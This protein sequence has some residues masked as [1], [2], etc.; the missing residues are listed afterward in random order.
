MD[1]YVLFFTGVVDVV[2]RMKREF[3][4][5]FF[6]FVLGSKVFIE[7]IGVGVCCRRRDF[8]LGKN[9]FI[10]WEVLSIF[11]MKESV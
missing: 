11:F 3:N 2:I 6:F 9:V 8:G 5:S 10:F 1:L 7:L 4:W